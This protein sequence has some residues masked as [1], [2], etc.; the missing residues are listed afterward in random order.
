[1]KAKYLFTAA[2][3]L[4]G[5]S[6]CNNDENENLTDG[7]VA[8]TFTGSIEKAKVSTRMVDTNWE[9]GNLIG[10][11]GKSGDKEY[12]NIP[13]KATQ[14]GADGKFEAVSE[15]IYFQNLN[16]VSFT[17][18]YPYHDFDDPTFTI[19][20]ADTREQSLQK[21][22]DFLYGTGKGSKANPVVSFSFEHRMSKVCL[23]VKGGDDVS[24]DDLKK[25]VFGLDNLLID[26]IFYTE[27]GTI[28]PHNKA[29]PSGWAFQGNE[30]ESQNVP[31]FSVKEEESS[32]TI[33]YTLILLPQEFTNG[34]LKFTAAIDQ[35]EV[36]GIQRFSAEI[37]LSKADGN[38]GNKLVSG[39]QYNIP[40]TIKK[41]QLTVGTPTIT[42]WNKKDL[43]DIEAEM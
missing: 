20:G 23:E 33:T 11:T 4:L 28:S 7:P 35:G 14:D 26:A 22:F 43:E 25:A 39:T 37:D 13:Y 42:P 34:N 9:T 31:D 29:V 41:T 16:E 12:L 3:L 6:A 36:T 24:F 19:I 1:M 38:D 40:I 21:E 17:A 5:M 27:N 18:Y 8:A 15:Q 30:T 10:I 2:A 32:K